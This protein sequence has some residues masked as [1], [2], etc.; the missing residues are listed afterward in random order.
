MGF[1]TREM[2]SQL[3]SKDAPHYYEVK[4]KGHPNGVTQMHCGQEKDAIDIC[5]KYSGSEYIKI[6]FPH[7]PHTVDVSYISVDPD[8]E[9]PMQQI[10]PESELEPLNLEL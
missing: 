1:I 10:L 2:R 4:I 3:V 7:P 5:E 8:F 9:L 6:Y